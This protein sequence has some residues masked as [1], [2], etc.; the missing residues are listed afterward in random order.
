MNRGLSEELDEKKGRPRGLTVIAIW[1]MLLIVD[2]V[3]QAMKAGVEVIISPLATVL[4]AYYLSC[5]ICSIGLLRL[6][7]W[8]RHFAV[9]LLVLH[10]MA[11]AAVIFYLLGPSWAQFIEII[12]K[13]YKLPIETIK[14]IF[15][16]LIGTYT[17]W[18]IIAIFY[19]TNPKIKAMFSED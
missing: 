11:F 8:A 5:F 2:G 1:L 9:G 7:N 4:G 15:A 6:R 16:A 12:S 13:T 19:L 18:Q 10:F 3:H 17:F 14:S